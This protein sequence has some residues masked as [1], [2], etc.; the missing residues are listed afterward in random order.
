MAS[1]LHDLLGIDPDDPR[2]A[3]AL[4]DAT[5]YAELIETLVVARRK[6]GLT[7]RDVAELMGTSQSTVSEFERAGGDARYSTLQRYARAVGAR[8]HTLVDHTSADLTPVW[9]PAPVEVRVQV[10][11]ATRE[12]ARRPRTTVWTDGDARSVTV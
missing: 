4:D 3:A 1:T 7:Q 8:L 9:T 12:G 6:C 11:V 2:T 5:A 10:R